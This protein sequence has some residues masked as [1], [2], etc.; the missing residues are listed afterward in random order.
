MI[1]LAYSRNPKCYQEKLSPQVLNN[2]ASHPANLNYS[3]IK[4]SLLLTGSPQICLIL[5]FPTPWAMP[6]S[7]HGTQDPILP[8]YICPITQN[9]SQISLPVISF[10]DPSSETG[11]V[12]PL[13]SP[14]TYSLCSLYVQHFLSPC[15]VLITSATYCPLLKWRRNVLHIFLSCTMPIA[16]SLN[17]DK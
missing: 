9:S 15:T 13:K 5:P 8:D 17:T 10:P 16:V 2:L 14:T 7:P 12:P 1:W 4:F 6:F 11:S 3:Y